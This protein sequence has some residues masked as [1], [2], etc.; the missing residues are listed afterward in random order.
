[1]RGGD[2]VVIAADNTIGLSMDLDDLSLVL[3]RAL[4]RL[5]RRLRLGP[6]PATGPAR[7][8]VVQIDGL[9]RAM[10]TRALA[11]GAM[12]FLARLVKRHGFALAPMSVGLPTSTASFQMAAMFGVRPDI[13][14]FH[15]H[16]KRR[17]ADVH[18]P[19]AGHAARV[20]QEQA[21]GR[22]GIVAGGST[23]GCVFTGGARHNLYSFSRLT[24][25]TGEGLL[26]ALSAFVV[27]AHV[28]AK[29][30][31][32]TLLELVRGLL[33][34]IANPAANFR[35]GW[36]WLGIKIGISI[37][38]RALFTLSVS[39]DLYAGVPAV[40]VNFLDYDVTGHAFG[41]RHRRTLRALRRIDR[42]LHQLWRVL[43]RVPEYRYDLYVLSDHGQAPCV[44]YPAVAG[45]DSLARR[46]FREFLDGGPATPPG[47]ADGRGPLSRLLDYRRGEKG[48]VQRFLNYLEEDVF[49]EASAAE[50]DGVR[51]IAA[52]PNAFVYVV[53]TPEPLTIEQLERRFPGLGE[54]LSESP[55]IGFVLVRSE[56]GPLCFWRGRRY[57]LGPG[58]A[59]PFRERADAELV[60]E[61]L[62]DLMAMPSAGDLVIYGIDAPGGHVSFIA[63][64]GAHAGPSP[65]E[66]Q[67]FIVAPPAV[68]LPDPITH[69][70]QLYAHFVAYQGGA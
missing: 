50:R 44:S 39:R 57:Q 11:Q 31:L 61:G 42:S 69:P 36:Q 3:Q 25:P 28:F 17:R 9:S 33:G 48:L 5:V 7:L 70:L 66:M 64:V 16:D 43:R 59:G 38:L 53:D 55:G 49:G 8:L 13:P 41:P 21:A 46:L 47:S 58:Q 4:D 15:Y 27:L 22:V 62:L 52:G 12:P 65:E 67:T 24:R 40:Y 18:F 29:S 60:V 54:A 45:G 2:A 19:R 68:R 10:L 23:Y 37:W 6:A 32:L 63:E 26:R 30:A 1:M 56:R 34:V 51:V 14:G 35:Q 20:E